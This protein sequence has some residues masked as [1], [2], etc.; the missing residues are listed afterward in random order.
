MFG[1]FHIG[2]L[3]QRKEGLQDLLYLIMINELSV[4]FGEEVEEVTATHL[5]HPNPTQI[6]IAT[7]EGLMLAS[8]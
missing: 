2:I 6:S 1:V 4:N 8:L 5:T 3:E 7:S